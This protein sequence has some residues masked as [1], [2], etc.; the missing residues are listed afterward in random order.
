MI[1][2][3]LTLKVQ[4]MCQWIFIQ[5]SKPTFFPYLLTHSITY[6][7]THPSRYGRQISSLT[8][9]AWLI[10]TLHELLPYMLGH[11]CSAL[12]PDFKMRI[13]IRIRIQAILAD[14]DPDPTRIQVI[15]M[16]RARNSDQFTFLKFENPST[17]S[18][19]ISH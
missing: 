1:F 13:Q 14:P 15:S 7:H 16:D 8:S 10:L 12:D 19:V 17:G 6:L 9:L 4:K 18:K 5:I 2:D 11:I 3:Y